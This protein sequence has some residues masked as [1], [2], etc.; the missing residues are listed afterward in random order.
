M[1]KFKAQVKEIDGEKWIKFDSK[2]E[3]KRYFY[4]NI[5]MAICGIAL[6]IFMFGLGYVLFTH[7]D[8]ITDNPF[9][10]GLSKIAEGGVEGYCSCTFIGEAG[11]KYKP[12]W[13]NSTS[14]GYED[15]SMDL[16]K[17]LYENKSF[18]WSSYNE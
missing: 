14:W 10:Y 2:F 8:E 9:V 1:G 5:I 17:L 11:V 4:G 6:M 12:F 18:N 16:S 7:L 13:A 15:N 3:E